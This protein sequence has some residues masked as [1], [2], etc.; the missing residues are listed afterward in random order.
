M[1]GLE[2]KAGRPQNRMLDHWCSKVKLTMTSNF[3]PELLLRM[4][5]L[6]VFEKLQIERGDRLD[7]V[8]K[9]SRASTDLYPDGHPLDVPAKCSGSERGDVAVSVCHWLSID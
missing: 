8:I 1:N 9:S 2:P 6:S 7:Q 4:Y 3:N 5:L